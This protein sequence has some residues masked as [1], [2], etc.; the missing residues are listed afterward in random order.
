MAVDFLM[1]GLPQAQ[2]WTI[3]HARMQACITQGGFAERDMVR[4]QQVMPGFNN[5]CQER[6][7]TTS[8]ARTLAR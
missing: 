8:L 7:R 6:A 1:S 3:S 2:V 4:V 5:S